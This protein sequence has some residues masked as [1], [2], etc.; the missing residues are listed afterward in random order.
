MLPAD[1]QGRVTLSYSALA[2]PPSPYPD[3]LDRDRPAP[4]GSDQTKLLTKVLFVTF[5]PSEVVEFFGRAF[6]GGVKSTL[7][8]NVD[9]AKTGSQSMQIATRTWGETKEYNVSDTAAISGKP[10][11]F[12]KLVS[13]AKEIAHDTLV[14]S[15]SNLKCTWN[16]MS[17]A[18]H[19]VEMVVEGANPLVSTLPAPA[20]SADISVGFRKTGKD[21]ECS[22]KGSHDG[23]PSY[24][25][26]INDDLKYTHDCVSTGQTPWSLFPPMEYDVAIDWSKL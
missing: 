14:V 23:F 22:I 4:S 24:A 3:L 6:N 10:D 16:P 7:I 21:W 8:V 1:L 26:F 2:N 13:G 15:D 25:V 17:G 11:W 19:G 18:S 9:L 12:R 20:I 5:I